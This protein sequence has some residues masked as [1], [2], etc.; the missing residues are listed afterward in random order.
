MS[1]QPRMTA[2]FATASSN[3]T[4]KK[5]GLKQTK[6]SFMSK[7][8]NDVLVDTSDEEE[9]I[10]I[11]KRHNTKSVSTKPNIK[12]Q[13]IMDDD[14]DSN[15]DSKLKDSKQM[16][17]KDNEKDKEKD[18]CNDE[19]NERDEETMNEK[20]NDL[21]YEEDEEE[22]EEIVSSV[23]KGSKKKV[24]KKST[25]K[26]EQMYSNNNEKNKVKKV[27][28]KE[29]P[30][31]ALCDTFAQ[32]EAITS[33]L[34]IQKLLTEL[35]R[36]ILETNTKDLLAVI[37]LASNSVAPAY[38]C[39]ELGVGDSLLIKAISESSGSNRVKKQYEALGDLGTTAEQFK[40]KVRT[41]GFGI[42]PKPLTCHHVLK[43][44]RQIATTSGRQS[45][46]WKVDQIQ[47]LL[48]RAKTGKEAKYIVRGL[49][50]KLRIGLAQSTVLISIAHALALSPPTPLQENNTNTEKQTTTTTTTDTTTSEE[51]KF[52]N[53]KLPMDQRLDA[54]ANII[55]K[56]YSEVP[57]YDALVEACLQYPLVQLHEK[58]TLQPGIPVAPMLAKPTKSIQ[59]I[60]QRLSNQRFT[61]EFKYDGERA[62]IHFSEKGCKVFSRNLLDTTEKFSE[63]PQY[64]KEAHSNDEDVTSYIMDAEVVAYNRETQQFV[65][66]QILSTRAKKT[67]EKER[68]EEAKVKVIVQAF[69]LMYLNGKS[70]LN[71][72]LAQ[73]RELLQKYFQPVDGR[74]Q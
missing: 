59:E 30:Y 23:T 26:K 6:L 45:Q 11:T 12:R 64:V 65:P 1:R 36:Q 24:A 33:R 55:K 14:E 9:P 67:T 16:D 72:T 37:Y 73:R 47:Q 20:D 41:L 57:S 19:S 38:E 58:C 10:R 35:F 32:I 56:A 7:K 68:E 66:F 63:V 8:E 3:N 52:A 49:Q 60:L 48:V 62:Q 4:M 2:F 69:D 17:E 15:H 53:K 71:Q 40:A 74:F 13:R 51:M 44:F 18:V 5:K 54:A 28:W 46:K 21:E 22:E 29:V 27:D 25:N 34:S 61:C 43:T 39:V 50:G 31:S 42:Q 70:L